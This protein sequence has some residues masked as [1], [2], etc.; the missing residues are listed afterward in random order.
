M[1]LIIYNA[2]V[3]IL[4]QVKIKALQIVDKTTA[5]FIITNYVSKTPLS[6][7]RVVLGGHWENVPGWLILNEMQQ[8]ITKK[9]FFP[10]NS[11]QVIFLEHVFEHIE[12]DDAIKFLKEAK[13]VLRKNGMI[14][15]ISPS[16]E[17]MIN[18][19][20][21]NNKKDKEYIKNTLV[22]LHYKKFDDIL[23]SIGLKGVEEDAKTFFLNALFRESEH[24]FIWSAQLLKK[25]LLS[26]GFK[27]VTIYKPG[28][29][30]SSEY[31]LERKSRGITT[32]SNT[33]YDKESLALE[34]I[35]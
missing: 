34:G 4:R 16:I 33:I 12:F 21:T 5:P 14:R 25:V 24:R 6:K 7:R 30:M 32:L 26:L 17:P 19:Q 1:A 29:G 2:V 28:E 31:C 9:L 10:T 8:D 3:T 18:A 20:F 23:K 11:I 22:R 35:K 15:I 27:K 13:R